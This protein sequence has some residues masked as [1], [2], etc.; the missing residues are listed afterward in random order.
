MSIDWHAFLKAVELMA[1][2]KRLNRKDTKNAKI[3]RFLCELRVFAVRKAG[4]S[5]N[6]GGRRDFKQG[7]LR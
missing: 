2:L 6:E 3:L 5:K 4:T 7:V 1:N